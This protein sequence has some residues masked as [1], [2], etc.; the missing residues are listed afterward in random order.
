MSTVKKTNGIVGGAKPVVRRGRGMGVSIQEMVKAMSE[1]IKNGN[2]DPEA[3]LK[4]CAARLNITPSTLE[5]KI[6]HAASTIPHF[7]LMNLSLFRK[8]AEQTSK[9]VSEEVLDALFAEVLGEDPENLREQVEKVREELEREQEEKALRKL[10]REAKKV[11]TMA[12][13]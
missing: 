11:K 3:N 9:P 7:R 6:R 1:T 2:T 5:G 4:D 13:V 12:T 10:D 8:T